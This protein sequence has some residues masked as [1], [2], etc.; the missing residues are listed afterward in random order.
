MIRITKGVYGHWDGKFVVPKTS[1]DEPFTL[2]AKEEARLVKLGVASYVD[3]ASKTTKTGK[4][5]AGNA[6]LLPPEEE[7]SGDE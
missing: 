3:K 7:L 5:E 2:S 6:S 4:E 1:A